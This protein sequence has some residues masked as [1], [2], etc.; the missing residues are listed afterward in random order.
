MP[1][2]LRLDVC[3]FDNR[4]PLLDLSPMMGTQ[5]FRRLSLSRGNFVAKF[6][7]LATHPRIGQG[8][9]DGIVELG[10]YFLG[11]ILRCPKT[12]PKGKV[13]RDTR[14]FDRWDLGC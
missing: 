5:R 8:I 4:P 10:D 14:L 1:P 6:R 11:R 13:E 9:D 12:T 7:K 3:G 2:L